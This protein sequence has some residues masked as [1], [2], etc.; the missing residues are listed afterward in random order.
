MRLQLETQILQIVDGPGKFELSISL[1][2]GE[3]GGWPDDGDRRS[4]SFK[5]SEEH[6]KA[7]RI[8]GFIE[9]VS[10]EGVESDEFA[11]SLKL[12]KHTREKDLE[13][14]FERMAQLQYNTRTRKGSIVLARRTARIVHPIRQ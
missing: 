9:S 3:G 12:S 10:R 14:L 1:L 8:S 2:D 4:V 5:L 6:R 13:D 11:L 7:R